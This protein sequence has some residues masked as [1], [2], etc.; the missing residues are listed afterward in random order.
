MEKLISQLG[1]KLMKPIL[2]S[3]LS[4]FM[5][6]S[7]SGC[8]STKKS[9][10]DTASIKVSSLR[11]G[12]RSTITDAKKAE[13]VASLLSE[14]E[15]ILKEFQT[16][17][18]TYNSEIK[19]LF[20]N[21]DTRRDELQSKFDSF[22]SKRSERNERV[23]RIT[24]EIRANTTETEWTELQKDIKKTATALIALAQQS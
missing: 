8:A 15:T 20:S 1:A 10:A 21:Y 4:S 3:A 11:E 2:I 17:S 22:N 16:E 12:V 7:Y 6:I 24:E 18:S 9:P 13:R 23:W 14:L 19:A 5:I